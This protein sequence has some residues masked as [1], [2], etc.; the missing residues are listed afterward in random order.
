M[1]TYPE[2]AEYQNSSVQQLLLQLYVFKY[3]KGAREVERWDNPGG[4]WR[5]MII[6]QGTVNHPF[7]K[8]D[9]FIA[10]IFNQKKKKKKKKRAL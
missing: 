2:Q 1:L 9:Y 5:E 10:V 4:V 8:S 6:I 7:S 3:Y